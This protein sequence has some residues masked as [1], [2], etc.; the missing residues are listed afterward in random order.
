MIYGIYWDINMPLKE[1]IQDGIKAERQAIAYYSTLVFLV[2]NGNHR[3]S[4][5]HILQEEKD[6]LEILLKIQKE[7]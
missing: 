6:H 2:Q 7:I 4:I 3:R 1:I 5:E